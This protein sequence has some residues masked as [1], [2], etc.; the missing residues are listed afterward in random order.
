M[1]QLLAASCFTWAAFGLPTFALDRAGVALLGLAFLALAIRPAGV[2][3]PSLPV[4]PWP[5]FP[6][7]PEQAREAEAAAIAASWPVSEA[8]PEAAPEPEAA[9]LRARLAAY[10]DLG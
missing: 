5:G 4:A 6:L 2:I 1:R 8:E 3:A 10:S 9:E 7:S